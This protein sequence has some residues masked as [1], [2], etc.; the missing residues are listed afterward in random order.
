LATH[1][2]IGI[3]VSHL[4]YTYP[5][6]NVLGETSK[7]KLVCGLKKSKL[8]SSQCTVCILRS[9]IQSCSRLKSLNM[10]T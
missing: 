4:I 7:S 8:N 1:T 6:L 9:E 3:I 2:I 5:N 10:S